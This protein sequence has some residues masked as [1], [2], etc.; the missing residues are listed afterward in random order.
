MEAM[1]TTR[2]TKTM[3]TMNI[4]KRCV[5][6]FGIDSESEKLWKQLKQWKQWCH[7]V[8]KEQ[9]YETTAPICSAQP[10]PFQE[11]NQHRSIILD[12][13]HWFRYTGAPP[14]SGPGGVTELE[15]FWEMGWL[16]QVV[17]MLKVSWKITQ[18]LML[19]I[20]SVIEKIDSCN[21]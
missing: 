11:H 4:V 21:S 13:G 9:L 5:F 10:L 17:E 2:T 18:L 6:V 12:F 1:K 7:Q 19:I 8:L 20:S 15:I 14:F 3:K 16:N